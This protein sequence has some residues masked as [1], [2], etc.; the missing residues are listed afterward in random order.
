MVNFP[1]GLNQIYI[2]IYIYIS[3]YIYIFYLV[4]AEYL[5][6]KIKKLGDP[7]KDIE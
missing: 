4:L 2:Y 7:L 6:S 3:I 1:E 5:W